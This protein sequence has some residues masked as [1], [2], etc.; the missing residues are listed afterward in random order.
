MRSPQDG[1]LCVLEWRAMAGLS[2]AAG[3]RS[4]C[5]V[6]PWKPEA[7]TRRHLTDGRAAKAG[8]PGLSLLEDRTV[9]PL[10][11]CIIPFCDLRKIKVF[12]IIVGLNK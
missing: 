8:S 3:D 7:V 12:L 5:G 1:S 4:R 11:A 2:G 6:W 9:F 10:F